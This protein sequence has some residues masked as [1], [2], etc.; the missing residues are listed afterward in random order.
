MVPR[1]EHKTWDSGGGGGGG[2]MNIVHPSHRRC[3]KGYTFQ[4][5]SVNH[6]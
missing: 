4:I 6:F 5:R 1:L 3:S 2:I